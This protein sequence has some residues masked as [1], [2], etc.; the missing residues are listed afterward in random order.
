MMKPTSWD[1]WPTGSRSSPSCRSSRQVADVAI[2]RCPPVCYLT[3][4]SSVRKQAR[5]YCLA[6]DR[7]GS[8]SS[9][10]LD[11]LM[12]HGQHLLIRLTYVCACQ[13]TWVSRTCSST[14]KR[15]QFQSIRPSMEIRVHVSNQNNGGIRIAT[16][17]E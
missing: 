6:A 8:F 9:S 7:L 12:R 2:C 4:S 15:R 1:V 3:L 13:H 16:D 11:H 5:G 17:S 10:V 14:C